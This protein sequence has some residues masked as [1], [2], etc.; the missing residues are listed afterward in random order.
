MGQKAGRECHVTRGRVDVGSDSAQSREAT[1]GLGAEPPPGY[2]ESVGANG[3]RLRVEAEGFMM[4]VQRRPLAA[5]VAANKK[6][7]KGSI[8]S[9]IICNTF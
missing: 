2:W 3:Q 7:Q 5:G 9:K 4:G 8:I 6:Q 1:A